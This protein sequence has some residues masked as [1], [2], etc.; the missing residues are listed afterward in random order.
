MRIIPSFYQTGPDV[1]F[2]L[3]P[4]YDSLVLGPYCSCF[5]HVYAEGQGAGVV[6]VP[7]QPNTIEEETGEYRSKGMLY[8]EGQGPGL[9]AGLCEE[10]E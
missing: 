9:I 10:C 1:T 5:G 4:P 3:V 8:V 6:Y 7:G 2:H